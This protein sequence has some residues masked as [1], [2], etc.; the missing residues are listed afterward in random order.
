M[1]NKLFIEALCTFFL[2]AG[3]ILTQGP[4]PVAALL[5]ALIYFGA[6]VSGAHYNP[7]VSLSFRLRRRG[8][9]K[10]MFAYMGVQFAA[11]LAAALVVGMI[12]GHDAEHTKGA[13]EA[14]ADSPFD[15]VWSSSA[16][17]V[18]GTFFLALVILMVGSSRLTA[19]NSYF[20]VAI[21]LAYLGFAGTFSEFNPGLNP[22]STLGS[23][24]HG[25][26]AAFFGDGGGLEAFVKEGVYLAK[27]A[28]RILIDILAQFAGGALAAGAFRMLFPEDR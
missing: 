18:M 16:V 22:A 13:V 4:I 11:A 25:V 9:T 3:S 14:L 23:A 15:G 21:A 12:A 28:P 5:C 20:G 8:G 24:F 6:P 19:G 17:E 10:S 27:I 7:A 1:R 26:A 2:C